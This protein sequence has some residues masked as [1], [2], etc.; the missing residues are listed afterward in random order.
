M[1]IS[2]PRFGVIVGLLAL[3]GC[4]SFSHDGGF[5]SV[6]QATRA[7][8]GKE[9]LWPRTDGER[10]K[11]GARVAELLAHPL[12]IDAAVQVALLSNRDLQASFEQLGVSEADLVQSGRLPN[13][14]FDF[15]HAS[16]GGEYDIEETVT[17]NVVALLTMSYR[18][19]T[20]QR[21]FAQ[22]QT[23]IEQRVLELAANTRF[24]YLT[25]VA[26]HESVVFHERV[27]AAA[28]ASAELARRMVAAGNWNRIDQARELSFEFDAK[29]SLQ[30]A[31]YI[32]AASREK[33]IRLLGLP[34]ASGA[35][36]PLHLA[37][38]LPDLPS[39]IEP[40]PDV[41][42]YVLENRVD[43]QVLRLG[44]DQLARNLDLAGSTRFVN[45]LEAGPA[46]IKQGTAHAGYESGFAFSFEVPIFDT[47]AARMKRAEAVY[48]QALDEFAQ[49]TID[50]RSQIRQSYANYQSA[51]RLAVQQRDEVLPLRKSMADQE[52]LRYNASLIG[53]FE[54]LA[55]ARDQAVSVDEYM[56]AACDFWIAK[57]QFDASLLGNPAGTR[58]TSW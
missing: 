41:E 31:Q 13:P 10:A 24:A 26:A 58:T 6:A 4:A 51:Y 55:S 46:R 23:I 44:L 42:Q 50:A 47:G 32:E 3:A 37:E 12:S 53:I 27:K 40:L 34:N 8:L 19:E 20:E 48:A 17:L 38:R 11:T 49:A 25:A 39:S 33:L 30:R 14:R 28:N 1:Q 21:R 45:V 15:L 54:L 18:H 22:A 5:D 57:S 56:Q 7:H 2:T 36:T 16:A 35:D 29:Q 52:L 9:I 43:L